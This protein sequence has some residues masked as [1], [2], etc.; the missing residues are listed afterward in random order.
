MAL[1]TPSTREDTAAP[2]E[3]QGQLAR[4]AEG[5]PHE[6]GLGCPARPPDGRGGGVCAGHRALTL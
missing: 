3:V 2:W 1:T 6:T 4:R 5:G